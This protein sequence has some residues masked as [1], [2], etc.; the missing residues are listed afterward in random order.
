VAFETLDLAQQLA[1]DVPSG[2]KRRKSL[3]IEGYERLGLT[4][5]AT[6]TTGESSSRKF[7]LHD[8]F[9]QIKPGTVELRAS[10]EIEPS[11]KGERLKIVLEQKVFLEIVDETAREAEAR[12]GEIILRFNSSKDIGERRELFA[13]LRNLISPSLPSFFVSVL[14]RADLE[15]LAPFAMTSLLNSCQESGDWEPVVTYLTSSGG[16]RD[17]FCL[18]WMHSQGVTLLPGQERTLRSARNPWVRLYY[19]EIYGKGGSKEVVDSFASEVE[20]LQRRISD[21]RRGD[22]R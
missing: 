1:F 9:A 13:S 4:P 8:F 18:G 12:V 7:Y 22:R 5:A 17:R 19:L 21:L 14:S 11:R 3:D 6:L 15:E 20:D 2:W 10:L 16:R